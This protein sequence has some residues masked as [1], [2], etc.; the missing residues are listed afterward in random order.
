MQA[1]LHQD[2]HFSIKYRKR[3]EIS[4]IIYQIKKKKKR[5]GEQLQGCVDDV[6]I[7]S[8]IGKSKQ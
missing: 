2:T 4:P 5:F 8:I 3:H 1:N 6:C 7:F